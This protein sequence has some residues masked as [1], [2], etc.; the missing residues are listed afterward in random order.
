MK[1]GHLIL[2]LFPGRGAAATNFRKGVA[3]LDLKG[4]L[5]EVPRGLKVE[6]EEEEAEDTPAQPQCLTRPLLTRIQWTIIRS[7]SLMRR[8]FGGTPWVV[9]SAAMGFTV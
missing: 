5:M 7:R 4:A 6:E 8:I 2:S 1:E 9:N 3:K